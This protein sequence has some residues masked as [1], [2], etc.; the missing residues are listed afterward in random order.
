MHHINL[1][2]ETITDI[3]RDNLH[4]PIVRSAGQLNTQFQFDPMGR[5]KQQ[6]S[7]QA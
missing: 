5:L 7:Q 2:G 6:I 3:E 4:R 1:N